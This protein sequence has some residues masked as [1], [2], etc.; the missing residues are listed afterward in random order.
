MLR[1]VATFG[2]GTLIDKSQVYI[3]MAKIPLIAYHP[4]FPLYQPKSMYVGQNLPKSAAHYSMTLRCPRHLVKPFVVHLTIELR[5]FLEAHEPWSKPQ[6]V[7]PRV[8]DRQREPE[9]GNREK[10]QESL[11]LERQDNPDL[12]IQENREKSPVFIPSQIPQETILVHLSS[13]SR[14]VV[15]LTHYSHFPLKFIALESQSLDQC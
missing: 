8:Q 12:S 7:F 13:Y 6:I 14:T 3:I 15:P 10:T 9:H 11:R 2:F 4:I 1:W 5:Q